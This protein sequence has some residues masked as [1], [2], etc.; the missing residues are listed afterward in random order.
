MDPQAC[1]DRVRP[2]AKRNDAPFVAAIP[3]SKSYTNRALVLASLRPGRTAIRGGLHCDDTRYLSECLDAFAGLSVVT[4]DDG[5]EV[6]RREGRLGAPD[7][8]LYAG[9]AG[10]PA[11]F[12]LAFAAAVEGS[13]V[14]TGNARLCERPM[15]DLIDALRG[16]GIRVE[17]QATPGCLPVRVTGGEIASRS[18]SIQGSDHGIRSETRGDRFTIYPATPQNDVMPVEVDA[19]AMSYFLVAAAITGTT[20]RIEGIDS[21]SAQ[22]DVGLARALERMGCTLTEEKRSLTLTGGP[23]HGIDIDMET[24]PDVVLSLAIAAGVAE[25]E[26]RI[27]NIANLRVKECDRIHAA[28]SE[29][30][31]V[32]IDAEQGEDFLVIRPGADLRPARV[33]TY[34][35]H[36]V[37]MS[38]GLYRLLAD[39]IEIEEPACVAK[40]FPGF[41]QELARFVAH[42]RERGVS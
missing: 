7:G 38:F 6:E 21:G 30:V 14:V 15:G 24:M 4:T 33:E 25:G 20:V 27:T 36:R 16:L 1:I 39:G 17:S 35:D 28:A 8:P 13:S 32:G 40:S 11:R 3:G 31:R 19:S 2:L 29:L 10:T 41:W 5:F 26:T 9:G 42:H 34:D 18:W 22:G 12:L 23:L 37:A